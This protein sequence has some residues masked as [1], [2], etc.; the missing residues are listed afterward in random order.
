MY[1][2]II[3]AHPKPDHASYGIVEGAYVSLTDVFTR[4]LTALLQESIKGLSAPQVIVLQ[5][6][7]AWLLKDSVLLAMREGDFGREPWYFDLKC[8]ISVMV[9]LPATVDPMSVS[10][11]MAPNYLVVVDSLRLALPST[12][13]HQ[14]LVDSDGAEDFDTFRPAI[15][16]AFARR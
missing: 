16:L 12:S 15:S 7:D 4:R 11:G 1:F 10:L 5:L 9:E 8:P 13:E 6:D 2:L 14:T 3:E